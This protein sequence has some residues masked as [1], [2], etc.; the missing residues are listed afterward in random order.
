MTIGKTGLVA[1][2]ERLL[3]PI[4]VGFLIECGAP[5]DAFT[6]KPQDDGQVFYVADVGRLRSL[7]WAIDAGFAP[8]AGQMPRSADPRVGAAVMLVH[9]ETAGV[10]SGTVGE[11]AAAAA[12]VVRIVWPGGA[13]DDLTVGRDRWVVLD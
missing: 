13:E 11:A 3:A 2:S 7:G 8:P 10:P 5:F 12:D 4:D 6:A 9:S 1:A